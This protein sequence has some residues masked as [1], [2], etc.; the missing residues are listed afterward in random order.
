M[1]SYILKVGEEDSKRLEILSKIYN[2]SSY[3]FINK[4][5]SSNT[6]NILDVG[7]G[8]GHMANWFSSNFVNS[9][10]LAIDNSED[11]LE[12]S[13]KKF[14]IRK[15]ISFVKSNVLDN[16]MVNIVTDHFP[17]GVDLIYCRYLL[18][19]LPSS[20]WKIFFNNMFKV[21]KAGGSLIIEEQGLSVSSYPSV[22]ALSRGADLVKQ[23]TKEKDLLFDSIE[24]LWNHVKLLNKQF[25][26]N[27][28][29]L[30]QPI[31]RDL[32][33][34]KLLYDSFYQVL[35]ILIETKVAPESEIRQIAK[36]LEELIKDESYLITSF[37]L[38]QLHLIKI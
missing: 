16:S 34:R 8:H 14:S 26:I 15:N 3:E 20:E 11:Q 29:S 10:I 19:H 22:P 32:E 9:N 5:I 21:L 23:A 37:P 13:K 4:H 33:T 7:T 24:T 35:P 36:E 2:P 25:I 6:K 31:L 1:S 17:D 18:I 12:V 30:N 38:L 27:D 28:N